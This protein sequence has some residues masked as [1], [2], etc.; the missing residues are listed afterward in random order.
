MTDRRLSSRRFVHLVLAALLLFTQ[1]QAVLHWLSHAVAAAS[2]KGKT[3]GPVGDHC[4]ECDLLAP[5]AASIGSAPFQLALQAPVQVAPALQA[6]LATPR[7][8]ALAYRSRAPP[9]PG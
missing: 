4:D 6:D 9:F 5:L 8:P 7:P 2:V 1:Q 3:A